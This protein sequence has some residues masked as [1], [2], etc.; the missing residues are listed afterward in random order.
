M[1]VLVNILVLDNKI[2]CS[3]AV[4]RPVIMPILPSAME[5]VRTDFRQC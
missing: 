3:P 1:Y 5:R 2:Q 4:L